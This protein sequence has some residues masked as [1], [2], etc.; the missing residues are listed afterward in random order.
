MRWAPVLLGA[1]IFSCATFYE[2]NEEFNRNFESGDLAAA[3]QALAENKKAESGKA[4]L[5]Y[6]L[7]RGVANSLMGNYEKS[8]EFFEQAHLFAEDYRKNYAEIAVSFVTNP[9]F[10]TYHGEDHEILFI[11]YYKALNYLKL[12]DLEAALVECR[13]M[14][15]KL[16]QLSD[17]YR[18]EKKYQRDA[19]IHTLMGLVYDANHDYNNAFIAYRNAYKIYKEDYRKLFGL[20]APKQLKKDLLRSAALTG[21]RDE[22]AYYEKEFNMKYEPGDKGAGD[23]IFLWNNGL[24][25]I[26][27]EWSINFVIVKGAGGVVVFEN[28]E[29]GF[30]FPFPLEDNQERNDLVEDLRFVRVAFPKYI[31]RPTLFQDATLNVNGETFEL[32][33]AENVNKI[34]KYVLQERMHIEFGKALL[35]FALKKLAE[36]KARDESEGLG[37]VVGLLNAVTEK[38]DTR[39]WQTL[40]H[41]IYYTRTPLEQGENEVV[42]NPTSQIGQRFDQTHNLTIIGRENSTTFYTFSSLETSPYGPRGFY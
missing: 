4:R 31:D 6:F 22:V 23:L 26:K 10:V 38:A 1:L 19:F 12:N 34:A 30:S 21:F 42:F 9:A 24:G 29:L 35:R 37:A 8:N 18:S 27:E 39:N 2:V 32:F 25:P 14:D 16:Q 40:P 20:D 11:H 13:R 36:K 15:I 5:V 3:D 17:K 41:S 33:L 7:N 28:E